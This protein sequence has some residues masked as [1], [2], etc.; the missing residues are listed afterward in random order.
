MREMAMSLLKGGARVAEGDGHEF[1][2]SPDPLE[3]GNDWGVLRGLLLDPLLTSEVLTKS[4]F[5]ED[6]VALLAVESA[7]AR[8]RGVRYPSGVEEVGGRAVSHSE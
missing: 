2:L 3:G 8:R 1:H 7:W 5:D 6:Q 4:D